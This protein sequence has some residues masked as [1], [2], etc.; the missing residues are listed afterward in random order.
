MEKS[1]RQSLK[2]K[3]KIISL[4]YIPLLKIWNIEIR[5]LE[6]KNLSGKYI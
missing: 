5:V 2:Q 6:V 4:S 1:V 3:K